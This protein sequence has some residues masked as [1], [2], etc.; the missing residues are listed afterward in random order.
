MWRDWPWSLVAHVTESRLMK[1]EIASRPLRVSDLGKVVVDVPTPSLDVMVL[2]DEIPPLFGLDVEP[3]RNMGRQFP[4]ET[5]EVF[6]AEAF[7]L[8]EKQV[9]P[10]LEE[11]RAD[12]VEGEKHEDEKR[13]HEEGEIEEHRRSALL[14]QHH[15]CRHS[16]GIL[17]VGRERIK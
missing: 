7:V 13:Q 17:V 10:A 15:A 1:I 5:G 12:G 9:R 4:L 6:D 14:R 16:L 8:R 2:A 3:L 11:E